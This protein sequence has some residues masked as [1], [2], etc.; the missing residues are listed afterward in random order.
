ML[1]GESKE[2]K[3]SGNLNLQVVLR[4]KTDQG[5]KPATLILVYFS[6]LLIM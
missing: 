3:E 5:K 6:M 4:Q 1:S 2:Q